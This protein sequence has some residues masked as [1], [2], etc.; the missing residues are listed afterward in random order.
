VQG[1]GFQVAQFV[2]HERLPPVLS[3]GLRTES[4]HVDIEHA[5]LVQ[6]NGTGGLLVE[7]DR[8]SIRQIESAETDTALTAGELLS[9]LA[10]ERMATMPAGRVD[11][12]EI[13]FCD[14][15]CS[16]GVL[17][18]VKVAG[19]Q[20]HLSARALTADLALRAHEENVVITIGDGGGLATW[21]GQINTSLAPSA[22]PSADAA[23]RLRVTV[24]AHGDIKQR[25]ALPLSPSAPGDGEMPPHLQNAIDAENAALGAALSG[26]ELAIA[27]GHLVLRADLRLSEDAGLDLQTPVF[28]RMDAVFDAA[29]QP[30]LEIRIPDVAA[31]STWGLAVRLELQGRRA[32]LWPFSAALT[33][34]AQDEMYAV[35]MSDTACTITEPL[36]RCSAAVT[37]GDRS[38]PGN[39]SP[40]ATGDLV[41]DVVDE[42]LNVTGGLTL[43]G[44]P[45]WS[46]AGRSPGDDG[47]ARELSLSWRGGRLPASP[48]CGLFRYHWFVWC[49][50]T[51]HE[52][53]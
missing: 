20:V 43:Y 28:G 5:R 22:G 11:I 14:D 18:L 19:I 6:W 33:V 29:G 17:R 1:T 10:P 48:A 4:L 39:S 44:V 25:L 2:L 24:A 21:H 41:L 53:H 42:S 7:V 15:V 23:A 13:L 3:V 40:I 30:G 50:R 51:G 8:V 12:A 35:G 34:F 16:S 52:L 37:V 27:S 49:C 9:Y 38:L 36:I 26:A 46:V 45:G 32:A 31:V 47:T